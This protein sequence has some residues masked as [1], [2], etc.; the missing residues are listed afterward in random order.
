MTSSLHTGADSEQTPILRKKKIFNSKSVVNLVLYLT[1]IKKGTDSQKALLGMMSL[2]AALNFTFMMTAPMMKYVTSPPITLGRE[3]RVQKM[4][5]VIT[6]QLI[7]T[8]ESDS[9][10][11]QNNTNDTGCHTSTTSTTTT[12]ITPTR[13]DVA[14]A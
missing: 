12:S 11:D 1:F 10:Y 8:E 6:Y 2:P 13:T 4:L 5:N 7:C 14:R 9:Q 3:Q